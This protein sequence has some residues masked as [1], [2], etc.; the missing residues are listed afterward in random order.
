MTPLSEVHRDVEL[1]PLSG[2]AGPLMG[3]TVWNVGKKRLEGLWMQ[4]LS[5]ISYDTKAK[6]SISKTNCHKVA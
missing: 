4:N 2:L 5:S 1:C 6:I 3:Q